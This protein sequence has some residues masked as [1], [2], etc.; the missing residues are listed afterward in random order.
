MKRQRTG[1]TLVE[2]LVVIAIIGILVGLLLP[3][4]GAVRE[5]MRNV[6]CQNNMRQF[7]IAVQSF[8]TT[9]DRLP[10]Y[11]SFHGMYGGGS[12]PA[13]PSLSGIP[14]HAKIGG[15][16]VP[17]LPY[18]DQ[19]TLFDRWS[20]A[21]YPV[22]TTGANPG[23][24]AINGSGEGWNPNSCPTIAVFQCPSNSVTS[25]RLG[26]NSYVCNTGSVDSG[27][28]SPGVGAGSF[29]TNVID[30]PST[31]GA[32]F[33]FKKSENGNNGVFK[34]GYPNSSATA[35]FVAGDKMTMEDIHD[36]QS[37]TALYGENIQACSWYRP[38]Y[39]NSADLANLS[40]QDLNWTSGY[41][42]DSSITVAQAYYRGKFT[43]GMVWHYEDPQGA[44]GFPTVN[45]IHRIN[46]EG[47]NAGTDRID[48]LTMTPGNCRDLARPS[49]L[50]PGLVNMTMADGA[51]KSINET[52]DYD[53]YQALLTPYGV[54]SDVPRPEF[55]LT[56]QLEE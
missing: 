36:G 29:I 8:S 43:T 44:N 45:P 46:G 21:K 37:Q 5:N 33:V 9:K 18:L 35:P 19:Q 16:G 55:V 56:N 25:G 41:S 50:H 15:F 48:I 47:S 12:D 34:I 49:S 20:T 7:G 42:L 52:I 28:S 23:G 40:G 14:V 51:V 54:K 6:Q 13:D 24:T 10:T 27:F 26:W 30:S 11:T 38:G 32:A 17:L 22:I 4:I 3:A 39:L 31:P 53:V 2:L 1:F